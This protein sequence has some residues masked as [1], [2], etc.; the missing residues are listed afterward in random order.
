MK[1][2]KVILISVALCA[3]VF[4]NARIEA[5]GGDAGFWPGDRANAT[6]FP[7]T[8][9]DSQWVEF[10]GVEGADGP[11][12]SINW[13]GDVKWGFNFDAAGN[14]DWVNITWAKDGMGLRVAMLS[15]E[16]FD[17]AGVSEGAVSGFD[18]GWGQ[19]MSFGELGVGYSTYDSGAAGS[20]A[21]TSLTV[22]WRGTCEAWL[23]DNAKASLSMN[24]GTMYAVAEADM[25]LWDED[26]AGTLSEY[27]SMML[28]YDLFTHLKPADGVTA[29][30][31][32]GFGYWSY[33]LGSGVDGT[34]MYLP[35]AL[36][37]VE[38]SMTDWATVRAHVGQ[39]HTFSSD[40]GG[41]DLRTGNNTDYGFGVGFG[42]T[43]SNGSSVS[44]D[45]EVS[46]SLFTDPISSM[47]GYKTGNL[48]NGEVTV[49]YV[50]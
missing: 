19:A 40:L 50:F 21:Q 17:D 23:F 9:N 15:G 29:L 38:A 4:A 27:S 18:L 8:L 31:A 2:V 26:A 49:S 43:T 34:S 32:M 13:G 45:M 47:T 3:T 25:G 5:L 6:A 10:G 24:D 44:L 48:S 35:N 39:S 12:A 22:N 46:N 42:W 28:D 11:S 33:D 30:V 36:V 37:A 20:E 16:D 14:D 7:G 1:N 41:A